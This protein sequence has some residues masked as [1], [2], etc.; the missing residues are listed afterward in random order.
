MMGNM[1]VESEVANGSKFFFTITSQISPLSM[2]ATLTKMSPFQK[3]SILFVDTLFD[4]TGVV[5]RVLELGL[6][7]YVVHSV[8]EVADK[9][10]C[11]HIDTIVVDSLL[12]VRIFNLL[13]SSSHADIRMSD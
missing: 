7:P 12:V 10:T 8:A 3:R 13:L 6:R 9:T 11:P 2:E 5:Q 4:R 1:W